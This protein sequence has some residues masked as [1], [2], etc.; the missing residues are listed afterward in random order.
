[1]PISESEEG[2]WCVLLS[3]WM[4]AIACMLKFECH[5]S[6]KCNVYKKKIGWHKR[7][8]FNFFF[9]SI[10]MLSKAIIHG[11]CVNINWRKW[12]RFSKEENC[13]EMQ[14]YRAFAIG[15]LL[16]CSQYAFLWP[17]REYSVINL[18]IFAADTPPGRCRV[19]G[20]CAASICMHHRLVSN[21]LLVLSQP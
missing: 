6:C 17:P 4:H 20:E 5:L 8:Q 11:V 2:L 15:L 16:L 3:F 12:L 13:T 7:I 18:L 21:N 14:C 19:A 10:H 9:I 1:M